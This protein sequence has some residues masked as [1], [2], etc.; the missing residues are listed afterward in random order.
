MPTRNVNLTDHF[1]QFIAGEIEAGRY[2]N[3]SEVMRA[4]LRLLEQ[5]KQEDAQRLEKLRLLV[6]EGIVD[7]ERGDRSR[8][9]NEEE[10][11][12]YVA[13]IGRE[14]RQRQGQGDVVRTSE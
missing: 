14:V 11:R 10:I 6:Q 8:L 1:D 9:H 3:A 13:E 2:S 7:I 4:G 5:Q 12:D